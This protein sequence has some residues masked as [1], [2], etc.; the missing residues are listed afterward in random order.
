[1]LS[2]QV[3]VSPCSIAMVYAGLGDK[4]LAFEWLE[5]ALQTRDPWLVWLPAEPNF[6]SLRIDARFEEML[7]R[8][9]IA[10]LGADG[11]VQGKPTA[12][13]LPDLHEDA[14]EY[15]RQAPLR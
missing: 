7:L 12:E 5:K 10:D 3:Y 15:P 8:I 4:D 2:E 1:M 13:V 11:G 14:S 6:D 9:G